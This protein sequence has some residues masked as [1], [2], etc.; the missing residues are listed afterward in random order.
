MLHVGEA[1]K[2]SLVWDSPATWLLFSWCNFTGKANH[3]WNLQR[4]KSLEVTV[5]PSIQ[6]TFL[7]FCL[8][9]LTD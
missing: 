8:G 5:A 7:R 4:M 3:T 6:G 9:L 1:V 2:P